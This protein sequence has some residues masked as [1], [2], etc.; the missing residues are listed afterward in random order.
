MTRVTHNQLIF[1]LERLT[2]KAMDLLGCVKMDKKDLHFIFI[3]L[4]KAYDIVPRKI[5]C[6]A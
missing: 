4:E 3:D 2:M 1:M 5:L 6:K